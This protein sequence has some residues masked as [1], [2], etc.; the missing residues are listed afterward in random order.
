MHVVIQIQALR[1]KS[2]KLKSLCS[3]MKQRSKKIKNFANASEIKSYQGHLQKHKPREM[4]T[5]FACN[6][7]A[8]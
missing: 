5:Q 4:I 1:R 7:P 2:K 3:C 8:S 6:K